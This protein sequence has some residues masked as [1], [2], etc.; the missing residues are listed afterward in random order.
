MAGAVN[1][2]MAPC[3][4]WNEQAEPGWDNGKYFYPGCKWADQHQLGNQNLWK[5][6]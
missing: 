5:I 2:E 3:A 6:W 4:L 1:W